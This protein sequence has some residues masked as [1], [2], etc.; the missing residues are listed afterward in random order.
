MPAMIG[1]TRPPNGAGI[2]P[3]SAVAPP[4]APA[5]ADHRRR[6]PPSA[7]G[8]RS[9]ARRRRTPRSCSACSRRRTPTAFAIGV[10]HDL[11]GGGLVRRVRRGALDDALERLLRDD[12]R[13][14]HLGRRAADLLGRRSGWCRS[15]SC[16]LSLPC[17]VVGARRAVRDGGA[18]DVRGGAGDA[19]VRAAVLRQLLGLLGARDRRPSGRRTS[20]SSRS[21]RRSSAGRRRS[22]SR[23]RRRP[24]GRARTGRSPDSRLSQAL[25]AA[26]ASA[27]CDADRRRRARQRVAV[28]SRSRRRSCGSGPGRRPRPARRCRARPCR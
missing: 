15:R 18:G 19:A 5:A 4:P 16:E 28:L 25:S 14:R 26:I 20:A 17:V 7:P 6:P 13:D 12:D 24:G 22:R 2:S 3:P 1:W 8:R 9:G 23:C 11:R 21:S 10:L 27:V